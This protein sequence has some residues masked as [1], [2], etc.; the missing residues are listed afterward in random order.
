MGFLAVVDVETTGFGRADRVVEIGVLLVDSSSL[1]VVDE[2]DTLVNPMRDIG[3]TEIHGITASVVEAAPVFADVA[4]SLARMLDGGV[5]VAHN[6]PFDR[7]FIVAEFAR[8]GIELDPG[9][10]ICT[11]QLSGERLEI[12]CGRHGIPM[13]DQHRALSDARAT[14]GLLAAIYSGEDGLPARFDQRV[15][16][17]IPRTL[18]RESVSAGSAAMAPLRPGLRYPTSDEG[19]LSYLATVDTYLDDLVLSELERCSL[20]ELAVELRIDAADRGRLHLDYVL[21]LAGA[22][23]RD[24]VVT[25]REHSMIQ[26]V[27]N[28]LGVDAGMVPDITELAT[29][30]SLDGQRIC[31]TGQAIVDGR[32]IDRASLEALAA[33]HGVQPVASVSRKGCDALVAADP[34]SASGK[35]QKARGLGIPIISID[36]FLTMVGQ[37]R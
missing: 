16:A 21:A 9:A 30:T 5:V 19:A 26:A 24:G 25:D 28:A 33:R 4:G 22:A 27:A 14:H 7:R 37:A 23:A 3:A 29:V 1:E 10:G 36:E 6:L 31:F 32:L 35:A 18:R 11:L 17:G 13:P 15:P 20:D 34:S 2:F 12:A 8:S